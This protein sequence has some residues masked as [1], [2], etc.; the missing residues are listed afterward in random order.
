M[1]NIGWK[2]VLAD[3]MSDDLAHEID[4]FEGQMELMGQGKLDEKVFA[5]TRL[6]RAAG[7]CR[8]AGRKHR[9][10]DGFRQR[11]GRQFVP[12]FFVRS[13]LQM[14]RF[15]HLYLPGSYR[16]ILLSNLWP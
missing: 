13:A 8:S 1:S 10:E 3:K 15:Q 16:A 2:D 9:G 4:I 11:R 7:H 6:R 5:E 14:Y 12:V